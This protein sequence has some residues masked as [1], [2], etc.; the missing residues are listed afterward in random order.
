MRHGGYIIPVGANQIA[1]FLKPPSVTAE[2]DPTNPLHVPIM[3]ITV[4]VTR[5]C[6]CIQSLLYILLHAGVGAGPV[7]GDEAAV[8]ASKILD[9]KAEGGCDFPVRQADAAV[10]VVNKAQRD[11]AVTLLG[12][13]ASALPA[14]ARRIDPVRK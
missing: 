3:Q 9:G 14:E 8:A 11:I 10:P 12:K 1:K 13:M 4:V 7:D 6:N 2:M 5:A